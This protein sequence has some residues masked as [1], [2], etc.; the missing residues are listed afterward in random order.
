MAEQIVTYWPQILGILMVVV[1]FVK[2]KSGVAELRKDVDDIYKRD[3]YT[4]VVKLRAD[5]DALKSSTDEKTK[6][7]FELWNA[8]LHK[9]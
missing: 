6:S 4:Q 8:R 1:M 5:L 3:T 7:L 9:D 2:L